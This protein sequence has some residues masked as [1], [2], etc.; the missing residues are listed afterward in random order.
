MADAEEVHPTVLVTV[1]VRVPDARPEIVVLAPEP[2]MAPGLIVQL[3]AGKPLSTTLPVATV[4]VGC[5]TAPT[6]TIEG[7]TG[8]ELITIF[9]DSA[10]VQPEEFVTV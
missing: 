2:E 1:N 9:A 5:V 8:C 4:H 6:I 10:E 3:P 7:V